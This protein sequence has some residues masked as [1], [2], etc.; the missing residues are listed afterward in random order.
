MSE[1]GWKQPI[2]LWGILEEGDTEADQE[3]EGQEGDEEECESFNHNFYVTVMIF[4]CY[5][6]FLWFC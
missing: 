6:I 5:M 4:S 1:G 2:L 3:G